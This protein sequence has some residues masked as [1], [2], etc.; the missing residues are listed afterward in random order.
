[1]DTGSLI[2]VLG[3]IVLIMGVSLMR[4]GSK[5][6]EQEPPDQ[7]EEDGEPGSNPV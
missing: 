2:V 3:V 1:M 5:G 7:G 4:K 6:A